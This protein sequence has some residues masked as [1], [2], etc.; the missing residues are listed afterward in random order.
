[1][2]KTIASIIFVLLMLTG[3]ASSGHK[4]DQSQIDQIK[5]GE[6]TKDQMM[7]MFGSPLSQ[8]YNSDGKLMFIWFYMKAGPFGVSMKQQN[9]SVLFD[10]QNKV[11]KFNMIDSGN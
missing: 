7:K 11:F 9:L 3:C 5:I 6:T 10:D 2:S 4:I 1:M 8:A